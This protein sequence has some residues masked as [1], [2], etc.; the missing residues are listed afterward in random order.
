MPIFGSHMSKYFELW[1]KS[2][3]NNAENLIYSFKQRLVPNKLFKICF[4]IM[5]FF[6]LFNF[7]K[8]PIQFNFFSSH[9]LSVLL[10][11]L[12]ID[13]NQGFFFQKFSLHNFKFCNDPATPFKKICVI[14]T[15]RAGP[16]QTY[17][18][19]INRD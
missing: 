4:L 5:I 8:F 16:G 6:L 3:I 19:L 11:C 12:L 9:Q 13:L 17:L 2:I 15:R 18:F 7:I 14:G 10:K 1:K